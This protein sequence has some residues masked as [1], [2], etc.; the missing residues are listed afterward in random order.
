MRSRLGGGIVDF[1]RQQAAGQFSQ[2]SAEATL[3]R[4]VKSS[5]RDS[6]YGCGPRDSNYGC[7]AQAPSPANKSLSPVDSALARTVRAAVA[8]GSQIQCNA[9]QYPAIRTALT[10]AVEKWQ[11]SQDELFASLALSEIERLDLLF[12]ANAAQMKIASAEKSV[13]LSHDA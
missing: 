4:T 12:L 6:N 7:G 10:G 5:P 3:G 1:Y 11:G 8:A 9:K 13:S 2:S